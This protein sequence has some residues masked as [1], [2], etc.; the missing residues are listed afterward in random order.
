MELVG[1]GLI[2]SDRGIDKDK[3]SLT[4]K[5]ELTRIQMTKMVTDAYDM[6]RLSYMRGEQLVYE[7]PYGLTTEEVIAGFGTDRD[8]LIRLATLLR[9]VLNL[10]VP[11]SVP[12]DNDPYS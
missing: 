6:M 3:L 8:E 12:V 9:D 5:Q 10:A 4:D 11:G 2:K 7:N 1:M